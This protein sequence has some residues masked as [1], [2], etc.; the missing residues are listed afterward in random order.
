MTS[1]RRHFGN[2]R[3]L[4]SGRLQA[5]Y[6]HDGQR[7]LAP[8][9]YTQRADA[10]AFLESISTS[11]H[12]GDWVNPEFGRISFGQYATLWLAQR[13]DIRARTREYYGWLITNRLIP[14]FGSRELAQVT[15]VHV[16]SWYA[17]LAQETPSVARS[18]Y[19]VLRAIFNT[20]I[21]DDL[22]V[23]N[24]CRVKGGGTDRAGERRIPTVEQVTA[25]TAAV[26]EKYR[27][28]VIGRLGHPASGRG[29]R[30]QPP[31]HRPC[32]RLGTGGAGL[33]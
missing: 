25:L 18:A 26:P 15:P 23:K 29:A 11:I 19:R 27:A 4:P 24:P 22:I 17:D 20:A 12:R 33:P 31:R 2:V 8:N 13:T 30:S 3:K 10:Y 21:G 7:H 32:Y 1:S 16:R 9:I 14:R 5:G 28:A 6:W